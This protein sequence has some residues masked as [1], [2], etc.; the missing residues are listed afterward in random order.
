MLSIPFSRFRFPRRLMPILA[1]LAASGCWGPA[2][3]YV[4]YE[5][6]RAPDKVAEAK[7]PP[8]SVQVT[9]KR[10]ATVAMASS[11]QIMTDSFAYVPSNDM[12]GM[13]KKAFAL[14]LKNRGF[15]GG[16][17]GN[18]VSVSLSFYRADR[19]R[20]SSEGEMAASMGFDVTVT[21]A[22]G[23]TAFSHFILGQSQLWL[24]FH[25]PA[26][27]SDRLVSAMQAAMQEALAKTFSDPAFINALN[28]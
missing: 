25:P 17:G 1:V 8:V 15:T 28:G 27:D 9:D 16:S 12:A 24:G 21:R 3:E 10:S 6:T 18:V 23:S 5:P 26:D 2:H 13:L 11:A 14:E 19:L 20:T 7:S 22:D 4:K